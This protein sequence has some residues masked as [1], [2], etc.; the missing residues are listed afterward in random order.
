MGG[1]VTVSFFNFLPKIRGGL[2]GEGACTR[3]FEVRDFFR[4]CRN[5]KGSHKTS[6]RTKHYVKTEK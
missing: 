1:F 3:G 5:E 2:L 6:A 4:F